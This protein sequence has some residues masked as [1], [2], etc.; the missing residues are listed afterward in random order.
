M[1]RMLIR[2]IFRLDKFHIIKQSKVS[3]D[4]TYIICLRDTTVKTCNTHTLKTASKQFNNRFSRGQCCGLVIPQKYSDQSLYNH[5]CYC[6]RV[7]PFVSL[8]FRRWIHIFLKHITA[9]V[10]HSLTHLKSY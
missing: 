7:L 4:T 9:F 10:P 6:S 2:T 3:K 5:A 1:H 8:V